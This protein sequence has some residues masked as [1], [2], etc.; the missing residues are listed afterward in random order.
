MKKTLS[1]LMSVL[2]LL[3]FSIAAF[4][5]P[6]QADAQSAATQVDLLFSNFNTVKQ[7]D[8]S[9]WSYAVTDLDHNGKLELL[10]A[11][12]QGDGRYTA[13][14]AWEVSE[15]GKT[16]NQ[17]HVHVPQGGSFPDLISASADTFYNSGND[18]WYYLFDDTTTVSATMVSTSKCS[19][20][21]KGDTIEYTTYATRQMNY[22]GN[23]N[24]STFT[25][26]SG[27]V[28][29]PDAYNAA[30]VNALASA[31]RSS[32][33]FDWFLA[34]EVSKDRLAE[35]YGVFSGALMPALTA[36]AGA[37]QLAFAPV[38]AS[39]IVAMQNTVLMV[40]K[41]P[42][43]EFHKAGETALFIANANVWSSVEW[44]FVAPG[45]G[46]Y[47]AQSFSLTFPNASLDGYYTSNLTLGQVS[48]DM[49]GWSVYATF[50][51]AQNNQTVRTGAAYL[52]V[53]DSA[54]KT[55]T[56]SSGAI[57]G[58]VTN[59]Q[60]DK[61]TISLADGST[62]DVPRSICSVIYGDLTAGCSCTVYYHGG[63]A[64]ASNIWHVD[65]NGSMTTYTVTYYEYY[66][67]NCHHSV[68][69]NADVCPYCGYRFTSASAP[70]YRYYCPSCYGEIPGDVDICPYCGYIF[71]SG[72]YMHDGTAWL[73][74]GEIT[75]DD[76]DLG[77]GYRTYGV[78]ITDGSE[79]EDYGSG[80][81]TYGVP[82]TDGSEEEDYGSGSHTYGVP[83]TDGSDDDDYLSD[84]W[85]YD[86]GSDDDDYLSDYW[87]YDYDD[88]DYDYMPYDYDD[89]D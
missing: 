35:S 54:V 60:A 16:L 51:T 33:S 64:S 72:T 17:C 46:E 73:Y 81:R 40:T 3:S 47:S 41:Q 43:N 57:A 88:F 23:Q 36:D 13:L 86:Y 77:S 50:Y 69:P 37:A 58:V 38:S 74:Y 12:I 28:I 49:N 18:T 52:Y 62:V 6:Q 65:I 19:V 84:Y 48:A 11:S 79:E 1:L 56:I 8:A 29:T 67:P 71:A 21:K 20:Q 24:V 34:A 87:S 4:A 25:D 22:Q 63:K 83:I 44:T 59:P 7:N 31:A 76:D 27:N 30:G 55:K 10:A 2:M 32:T 26:A 82:I 70:S 39:G 66:C 5:A 75:E 78:P 14:N 45:G 42:T 15:D 89:F 53:S 85:S 80:Y 61:L 68:S 9:V